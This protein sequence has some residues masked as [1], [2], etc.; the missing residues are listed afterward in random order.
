[1]IKPEYTEVEI[2]IC[3]ATMTAMIAMGPSMYACGVAMIIA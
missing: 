2:G 1:M 3:V